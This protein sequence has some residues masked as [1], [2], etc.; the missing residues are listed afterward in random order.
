MKA[1]MI[2]FDTLR[3]QSLPCYGNE[4]VI[5][6]NFDRIAEK[7]TVFDNFFAGSLPCIP[8]RRELHT[9]RYNFLHRSWGPLEPFDESIFEALKN[10]NIYSHLVTDHSHYLEDGG[11]TYHNRYSTW[12]CFRGQEGDRWKPNIE[13]IDIPKQVKSVKSNISFKQNWINRKYQLDE[14]ETSMAKVFN[15]GIEFLD[16]NHNKD[17]WFL[18]IETFNPHEPFFTPQKYKD[19]YPHKYKGD[20][21]DWPSYQPVTENIDEI[22]HV[23]LQYNALVSMC[24]EY[25]G[26]VLDKMDELNLWEDTMLIINTDHGFLL[27]EHGWWG[28]NIQP[29]YNEVAELPFIIYNPKNKNKERRSE[30]VQ[31]IDIPATIL[32][33]FNVKPMKHMQGKSILNVINNHEKIHNNAL[34]GMHGGH[35]NIVNNDYIYMKA[36]AKPDNQP[37]YQYTLMPTNIRGFFNKA[38][39]NKAEL[40]NEFKFTDNMPILKVPS[41]SF[42][43]SFK[44]G[45]RLYEKNDSKQEILVNNYK[46]ELHMV[47]ELRKELINAEAPNEQFKRL[48]LYKDRDLTLDELKMQKQQRREYYETSLTKNYNI[49]KKSIYQLLTLKQYFKLDKQSEF[50]DTIDKYMKNNKIITI[51]EEVIMNIFDENLSKIIP[52]NKMML[53]KL[54]KFGY[55]ID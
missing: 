5:A 10:N 16:H 44:F 34:F 25:L 12:E 38:Q 48:G 23:N 9:G 11:A 8:A 27:S 31:T 21:F 14:E 36:S 29:F 46:A 1:I 24:D 39:L 4:D 6:P 26:K 50:E 2:M 7:S 32:D 41:T 54:V 19:L 37:L 28:K 40:T 18:Q 13:N 51:N 47:S 22:E 52:T 30:L 53:K 15:S 55:K 3:K 20:Y 45:D 17:D 35:V 49:E 43:N 33:Y 42:L